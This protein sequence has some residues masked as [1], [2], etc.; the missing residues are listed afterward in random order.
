MKSLFPHEAFSGFGP[1]HIHPAGFVPAFADVRGRHATKLRAG[2]RTDAP[3]LPGIYGMIDR[4]GSLIYVGKAKSLRARLMSYFREQSRDPKAGRII[5]RTATIVWE[6]AT[7]EFAALIRELELIQRF[8]PRYNVQGQPGN[9]R[10]VYV[11]LGR[12]PAPTLFVTREPTGKEM[13]CYGPLVGMARVRESVRRLNDLFRL[14]DCSQKQVMHFADQRALFELDLAP[15]CLR[16]D[17]DTCLGPC[18]GLCSRRQYGKNLQALR[19]FLDGSDRQLLGDLE[20]AMLKASADME[21]E[22]A[23][24]VRDKL[25]DLRRLTER[26]VWL[27]NARQDHSFIYP[28]EGADQRVVWYLIERG[29]VRAAVYPPRNGKSAKFVEG[30][31]NQIY[32]DHHETTLMPRRQVDSVLLVAAWFRKRV[33]ERTK[34]LPAA[35]ARGVIDTFR[36]MP[37]S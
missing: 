30:L 19:N 6:T 1:S 20:T 8:R 12:P 22:K 13:A 34:C 15:A 28:L 9:R 36:N 16:H 27:K 32:I 24:V 2:I 3:R 14:R 7:D 21:Y 37:K 11:C 23:M 26:L 25:D 31:L 35:E 33:E 5:S 17:I 29:Q 4:R 18:A 10:Y